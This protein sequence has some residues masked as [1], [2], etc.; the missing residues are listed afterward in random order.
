MYIFI[1]LFLLLHN[2][3]FVVVNDDDDVFVVAVA[4][5]D[6]GEVVFSQWNTTHTRHDCKYVNCKCRISNKT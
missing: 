6:D 1:Y 2:V 5:D 4:N 3:F